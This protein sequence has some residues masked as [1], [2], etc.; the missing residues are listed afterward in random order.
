MSISVVIKTLNEEQNIAACIASVMA[1]GSGLVDE[2]IVADSGSTDQTIAVAQKQP[3]IIVQLQAPAEAGCGAGAQLGYQYAKGDF[4]C[5][6]DGDMELAPDFL[7][8]ALAHLQ[9]H[10]HLAGVTGHV[11]EKNLTSLEYQRRVKRQR[12]ENPAGIV[13]RMN[14]GGL[15]R[16]SSVEETGYFADRN[17]HSYEE[18]DLGLR[19]LKNGWQLHRL[20]IPFVSHSGHSENSYHLLQKRWSSGYLFGSGEIIR[21]AMS[22]HYVPQLVRAL[23]ALKLWLMVYGWWFVVL[24]MLLAAYSHIVW[25]AAAA[26]II[27]L[28]VILMGI[29]QKNLNMGLYAVV[30]WIFHAAALPVGFFKKR[31]NPK[32]FITSKVLKRD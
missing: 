26:V 4:I 11:T 31:V 3:V 17:L 2:I 8:K 24:I 29:R 25:L 18:L 30:A 21:A 14:G 6:L 7:P 19:L 22:G 23:P 20:D 9:S 28:P 13:D 1:H 32:D 5:L 16:R 10:S 12:Y 27:V 15:Y